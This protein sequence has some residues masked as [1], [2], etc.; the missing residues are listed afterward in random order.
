MIILA[1]LS[2]AAWLYLLALHGR[3]W[4][5][6]PMLGPARP[7]PA[8]E[9]CVVVPARNEAQTIG[10]ALRSLLEQDY[11]GPMRVIMVDDRSTD[12]TIGIAR[13]IGD[14]RLSIVE[15]LDRPDGWSGKLW[16]VQQGVLAA[17]AAPVLL[18]TDADIEHAPGHL[19][20][21]MARMQQDGLDLVSEM[22]A[23]NCQSAAERWLV[24]AFVF[25]F[26]LL[27][28]FAL[29]NDPT[30]KAAAAAGGT[31]L[32][33]ASALARIGG[34]PALRGA[35]IDDVTLAT[36]IK[37]SGG[38]IFL[39]HSALAWS[40]RPY[41]GPGDVWRMVARTAFVQL[42][43]S[44]LL[45]LAC[46]LGMTLLF[47]APPAIALFGHGTAQLIALLAWAMAAASYLPTLR[48]FTLSPLRAPLLPLTAA[49]YMAATIGS[50][51]DHLFGRG[52]RWKDRAYTAADPAE[53]IT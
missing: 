8:P 25:F 7:D 18:L 50:A 12:G 52:V 32:V 15:G 31:M 46:T 45:V 37:R 3:F 29:V 53:T 6:G 1:V 16:A 19:S 26:Q 21:L 11:P 35:L 48:R 43:F 23:L 27:Y 34:L 14:P 9:I 30:R 38:G 41:P 36:R 22:V 2:F 47:L 5:A 20:S 10:G 28:P 51:F 17:G 33:R 13:A 40:R 49:F 24:P 39:G 44:W 42:R 4:S